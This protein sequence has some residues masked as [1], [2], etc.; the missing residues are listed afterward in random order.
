MPNVSSGLEPFSSPEGDPGAPW[1]AGALSSDR[2]YRRVEGG[3]RWSHNTVTVLEAFA[4][5]VVGLHAAL[6]ILE[7]NP[8][9]STY[10]EDAAVRW[11]RAAVRAARMLTVR[12]DYR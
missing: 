3:D 8:Q 9:A 7:D 10:W 1:T 12:D 5:A 4:I 6:T 11:T 2:H